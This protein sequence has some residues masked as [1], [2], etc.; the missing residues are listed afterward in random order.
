MLKKIAI[1]LAALIGLVLIVA[2]TK[3]DTFIVERSITINA[4]PQTVYS[5]IDDFHKW[6]EWSPWEKLDPNMERTHSGA[7]SGVGAVYAWQGNSDVGQ[8]RMEITDSSPP[9]KITIQLDFIAPMEASNVTVFELTPQGEATN[10]RWSM[11]GANNYV[12]KLMHVFM[13]M[14][15]LVGGDFEKGLADM[16]VAAEKAAQALAPTAFNVPAGDY[17]LEKHHA[18]LTFRVDHLGFSN[19]TAQFKRFDAQL[20]FDPANL[21]ASTVT[22]TVDPRSL[23]L[24]NPPAGFVETLLSAAWLD[25]KQFPQMTFK[26]TKVEQTAV[27]KVRVTG[28]FT[29]HGVTKPITLDATFNGGYAGLAQFDPNARIGFSA[30]GV[31]NRSDFGISYG[32]PEPGSKMGVSDAVEFFVEAEFS[33][34]PLQST[35]AGK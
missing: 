31:F 15:S 23:D 3:P 10:V 26:S 35:A 9:S 11:S 25:A 29:L 19:Y 28:D 2:A 1:V 34:P 14:D 5:L 24:V 18:T 8:G 17:S 20:T 22:A 27:N 13:S 6:G 33:G 21:A 32:I 4:P 30:R 16:K 12:A 7:A